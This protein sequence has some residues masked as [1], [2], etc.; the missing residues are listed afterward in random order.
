[1]VA[2]GVVGVAQSVLV[3]A[4]ATLLARSIAHVFYAH[5]VTGVARDAALLLLVFT[6]RGALT[7]LTSVLAHRASADVKTQL[8]HDVL[9][10]RLEAPLSS[11]TRTGELIHVVTT[12]LDALDGYF[13]KFLPQFIMAAL[14]P[15]IVGVAIGLND[16]ESAVI[17]VIT[18]PLIPIFMVLIGWTVSEQIA[19][20]FKVQAR[21]ANH[22]A[23]LV[24]GLPT[25]QVF[26]RAL[27]ARR[28]LRETEDANRAETLSTLRVAF[29]S[30]FVLELAATLSVAL[31]AVTIG[32]R[33]LYG[34]MDL[35][36]ALYILVL[37]PEVYLPL[38]MVGSHFHDSS[39][40]TAAA[41]A[42]FAVIDDA[43][44]WTSPCLDT[45]GPGGHGLTSD[46]ARVNKS[47]SA[48]GTPIPFDTDSAPANATPRAPTALAPAANSVAATVAPP[49]SATLLSFDAASYSYEDGHGLPPL[50]FSVAPGEIVALAGRS[51]TGKST[52]LALLLGFLEP[53]TGEVC[54]KGISIGS[55][56]RREWLS[57]IAYVGQSP[58]LLPGTVGS[59]IALGHPASS[60]VELR[61]VLDLVGGETIQLT[62]PIGDDA[63]GLSAGE[64]RRVAMARAFLKVAKGAANLLV[65]DEPT[66]GLDV[67]TETHAIEAI[68]NLHVAAVVVTHRPAVLAMADHVVHLAQ[69]AVVESGA[70][71]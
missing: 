43:A 42:A 38:R 17:I 40:G 5:D 22:F 15:I 8:R 60:Q 44:R 13:A 65:M 36:D 4:Q 45:R 26:G 71:A 27:A 53:T 11:R 37:A 50:S 28:G 34:Y 64:R 49:T 24:A 3:L 61:Q 35:R 66:A 68:R 58:G 29:L 57:N 52:A 69:L 12:G 20:R 67:T 10:A 19:R 2:V 48:S 54:S 33:T 7:W 30:A 23:D 39:N 1:L 70:T 55:L 41:D 9:A 31:I 16:F 32:F 59:N 63:E 47:Q 21:L 25:L 51:G 62:Q 56:N 46:V 14:V 6:V 18:V